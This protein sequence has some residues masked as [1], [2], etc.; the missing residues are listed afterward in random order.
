MHERG[1]AAEIISKAESLG[2]VKGITVQVGD[3][4]HLPANE[5][6]DVLKEMCPGWKVKVTRKQAK[7]KCSYCGYQGEPNILEQRHGYVLFNCPMCSQMPDILEGK[8]IILKEVDV[9]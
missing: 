3:L 9:E 8:D 6:E 4:A 2:K 5:M 1:I 7:V